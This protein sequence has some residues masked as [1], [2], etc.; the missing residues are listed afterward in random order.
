MSLVPQEEYGKLCR[1]GAQWV[2]S[3]QC[4]EKSEWEE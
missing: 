4:A 1:I 3:E 2:D